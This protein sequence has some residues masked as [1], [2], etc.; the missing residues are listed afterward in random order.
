ME[1]FFLILIALAIGALVIFFARDHGDSKR[2]T[3]S[4]DNQ[5]L[6]ASQAWIDHC[7]KNYLHMEMICGPAPLALDSD[8]Q[9]VVV[10]PD[11]ELFEPRAIRRSRSYYG[12]HSIRLAK[13]LS[14]RLG[15]G[16]SQ[17]E[18]QE[19]LRN[20]DQGTLVLT[21]KRLA[22]MGSLRTSGKPVTMIA[23]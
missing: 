20:I 5:K 19:E 14:L 2:D 3:E 15:T 16:M 6:A 21:T 13:G 7:A 18:S 1:P 9:A 22:F 4:G 11:V 8:E 23:K 17:S 12:G 10:L